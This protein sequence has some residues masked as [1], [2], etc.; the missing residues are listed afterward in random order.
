MI[1]ASP[2]TLPSAAAT[3]WTWR[4]FASSDSSSSGCEVP[5]PSEMSKADLPVITAVEPARDS[6]KIESNALSIESVRT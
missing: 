1:C 2:S 6:V 4:T 5:W 3:P